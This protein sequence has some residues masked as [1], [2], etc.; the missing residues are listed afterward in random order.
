MIRRVYRRKFLEIKEFTE[1]YITEVPS[2]TVEAYR[3]VQLG[4]KPYYTKE[5]F[6]NIC[7]N[8][9]DISRAILNVKFKCIPPHLLSLCYKY[10]FKLPPN[11][12]DRKIWD[13]GE[14]KYVIIKK[15]PILM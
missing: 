12:N 2:V 9:F 5:I 7:E 15:I 3:V 6:S 11:E 14:G 4:N 13:N 10:Y 1:K 8:N